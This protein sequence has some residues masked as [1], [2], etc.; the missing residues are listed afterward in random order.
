MKTAALIILDG[1]GL[2]KENENNAFYMAKTPNIDRLLKTC[3]HSKI[4]ASEEFVGLPKGQM[5]NSEVGHLNIGS[6]R[7]IYQDLLRINRAIEDG[8]LFCMKEL[9]DAMRACKREDKALHLMGLVSKGGVHSSFDHLKGLITMA[10]REGLKK[11]YIHAITDGRDVNPHS[12]IKDLEELQEFLDSQGVGKI[13]TVIGRYYAMDRDKRWDRIEIAYEL[14]TQ[15]KGEEVSNLKDYLKKSYEEDI[16]DEFIKPAYLGQGKIQDK[17]RLIF[18]NFRPD[19]ARQIVSALS[20][21][22][23]DGFKRKVFPKIEI[24]CMTS[25]D[26]KF[27][28]PVVFK[29]TIPTMTLGEVISKEG[30]LQLR[31][32]ETEKFAH[33]T[34]F[35]NGGREVPFEGEDRILI[36]SPKV[37][38]YDLKP[39]MSAYELTD[40]LLEKIKEDKY[41]LIIVNFANPDMVGH[42][43]NTKAAIKAVEAVDTCL[44]RL[45]NALEE[46]GGCGLITAD[47]GNCEL[48]K[49]ENGNPVTSHTTNQVFLI[50]FGKK[51]SLKDGALCDLAPSL[52]DLLN[53]KKPKEMTGNSLIG[54]Q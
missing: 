23:F 14:Y 41:S 48:M 31:A 47:H 42:T 32:A 13:A 49:D 5:G 53:I 39:E 18:F 50:M 10:K 46:R 35:F 40:N 21:K 25:Y 33:V 6:G 38:T 30:L 27:P 11:V 37:A 34:Y 28:L 7:V 45:V 22:D 9:L 44:G 12:A 24:T 17:D 20:S 51:G 2:G 1:L 15:G 8:S 36:P 43:G 54:G 16:T 4:N 29:E 52:L 19:R 3:P 26:K